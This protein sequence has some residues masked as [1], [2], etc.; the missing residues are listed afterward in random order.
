MLSYIIPFILLLSIIVFIHEYGHYYFAKRYGVKVTRFLIF[1][2]PFAGL[3]KEL[4]GFTDKSGTRWSIGYFPLGGFVDIFG[5]RDPFIT[6]KEIQ[7]KY[8]PEE[9]SYLLQTKKPYQK[10][11]FAFGGPLANFL[12]AIIIFSM[13]SIFVGKDFTPATIS[14]INEDGPAEKAGLMINDRIIGINGHKIISINDVPK[15]ISISLSKEIEIEV[16]RNNAKKS[17]LVKPEYIK[18]ETPIN[19]KRKNSK[20]RIIGIGIS[21]LNNKIEFKKIGPAKA[22][23]YAVSD[24]LFMCKYILIH[25]GNLL[26]GKADISNL[27]GPIGI[28]QISGEVVKL[29]FLPFLMLIAHISISLGLVNLLPIPVLDGGHI[30]FY[31]LEKILGRPLKRKTQEFLFR[32]GFAILM[33]LMF[34][35]FYVDFVNYS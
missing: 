12:T 15:L 22:I 5:S 25:I 28:A 11:L 24:T 20:R 32:I 21:A 9:Q 14:S 27:S 7:E 30:M 35:T 16:I 23:Y 19:L 17:Y 26:I 34:F 33:T 4:I 1:G 31:T 2:L 6:K 10:I 29:G 13:I 8:T 3:D 18:D